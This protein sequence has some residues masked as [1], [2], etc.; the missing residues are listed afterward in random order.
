V[1]AA[2]IKHLRPRFTLI[3]LLVV[4]TI[5][6]ILAAMLLPALQG[7][8][9]NAQMTQ[10]GSRQRQLALATALYTDD[11]DDY[12]PINTV[13]P[14]CCDPP[15]PA[16]E[17]DSAIGHNKAGSIAFEEPAGCLPNPAAPYGLGKLYD[18]QYVD[19][20]HIYYCPLNTRMAYD[21]EDSH[22]D[23]GWHNWGTSDTVYS[24]FAYR[25]TWRLGKERDDTTAGNKCLL[26]NTRLSSDVTSRD[27]D[28]QN[29]AD[30]H[31]A[32]IADHF[33]QSMLFDSHQDR[34]I[35]VAYMD[36]SVRGIGGQSWFNWLWTNL[37][38]DGRN[39]IGWEAFD[40]ER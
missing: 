31:K 35:N 16:T 22:G 14:P 39:Y 40:C 32:F 27:G 28:T 2:G 17:G 13:C 11:H 33:F 20:G 6:A 5:I 34:R 8:R 30:A 7:A 9:A 23:G 26:L 15:G 10:C 18:G 36:G 1:K 4:V 29:I 25:G 24:S 3:E 37:P 12:F 21:T 19:N 38:S